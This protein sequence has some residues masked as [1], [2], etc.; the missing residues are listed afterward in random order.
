MS[1]LQIIILC[2]T[3]MLCTVAA[4]ATVAI[5][6]ALLAS[7]FQDREDELILEEHSRKKGKGIS[8]DFGQRR[9]SRT[10]SETQQ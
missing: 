4:C 8:F 5:S 1:T 3:A 6:A 7:S 9:E 10:S 2:A